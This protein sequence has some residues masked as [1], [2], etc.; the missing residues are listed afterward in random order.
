[1]YSHINGS[2]IRAGGPVWVSLEFCDS[3][4]TVIPRTSVSVYKSCKCGYS[5]VF[6]YRVRVKVK[7]KFDYIDKIICLKPI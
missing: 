5:K 4:F 6:K 7:I 3:V 1:M 2:S